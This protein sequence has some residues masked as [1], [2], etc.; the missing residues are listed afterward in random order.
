MKPV[1]LA[2]YRSQEEEKTP[3]FLKIIVGI[4]FCVGFVL[5]LMEVDK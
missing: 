1:G 4:M 3:L 2:K 5:F